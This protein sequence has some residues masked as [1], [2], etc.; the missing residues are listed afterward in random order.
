[1]LDFKVW[2]ECVVEWATKDPYGFLAKGILAL[3][4]LFLA[5]AVLSWKLARM[6]E[7]REKEQKKKQ[8]CRE[9]IANTK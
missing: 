3:P 5:S 8:N 1:M 2:A 4:P 9:N 6:I 7:A